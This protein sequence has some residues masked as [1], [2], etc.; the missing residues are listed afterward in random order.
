MNG[1]DNPRRSLYARYCHVHR[2]RNRRHGDPRVR[3]GLRKSELRP[4]IA[5]VRS[6]INRR[7]R[8]DK[9][10]SGLTQCYRALLEIAREQLQ[11]WSGQIVMPA[12]RVQAPHEIERVLSDIEQPIEVGILVVALHL[13]REREPR[14]FVSDRHF[15]FELVKA[16][17]KLSSVAY[18]SYW[19]QDKQKAISIYKD[20]RP[21]TIEHMGAAWI[22][23][24][25]SKAIAYI[26]NAC[27]Q[28]LVEAQ[29]GA[30]LL[31]AG[32]GGG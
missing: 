30:E 24:T 8:K 18:G 31:S 19:S 6:V 10:E 13:M 26:L 22:V 17:R 27:K 14:R 12:W 2:N 9:V 4:Y 28:E 15:T 11:E 25:Y 16:F 29:T 23:P 21:A 7:G 5:E 3:A 32:F 20:L 1:C